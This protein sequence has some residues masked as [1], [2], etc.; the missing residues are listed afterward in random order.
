MQALLGFRRSL[1]GIAARVALIYGYRHAICIAVLLA[2][3]TLARL[4]DRKKFGKVLVRT[5]SLSQF[6]V[7]NP[8]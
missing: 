2:N 3:R 8:A 7:A 1:G 6:M 5:A 4:Y